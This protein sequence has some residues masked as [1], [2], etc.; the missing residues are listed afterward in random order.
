MTDVNGV[1][2]TL[3]ATLAVGTLVVPLLADETSKLV[4]TAALDVLVAIAAPNKANAVVC[5]KVMNMS[6]PP[7]TVK[8]GTRCEIEKVG[9]SVA[10]RG[11][12]PA[13]D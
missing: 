5:F 10:S 2:A 8:C 4:R 11:A 1:E 9:R 7:K 12:R 6:L 3:A 13:V